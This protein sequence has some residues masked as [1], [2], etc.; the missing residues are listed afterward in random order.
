MGCLVGTPKLRNPE[1]TVFIYGAYPADILAKG[2]LNW[3]FQ[4]RGSL[5]FGMGQQKATGP[6]GRISELHI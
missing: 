3:R 4:D 2:C 6:W 5:R 1:N